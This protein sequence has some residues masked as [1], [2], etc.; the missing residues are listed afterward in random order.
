MKFVSRFYKSVLFLSL[1]LAP[2]AAL[3]VQPVID[4]TKTGIDV[5]LATVYPTWT[6]LTTRTVTIPGGSLFNCEVTCTSTVNNPYDLNGEQDNYYA[7][8]YTQTP[9]LDGCVRRFD[10]PTF[11]PFND[12]DESD[13]LVVATTCYL[14][15][16]AGT[17]EFHCLGTKVSSSNFSTVVDSTSMHVICIENEG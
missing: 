4:G 15:E 6:V 16:L 5:P 14:P 13:K 7:A 10:F 12:F 9:P 11:D 2:S 3:A 1:T 17:H 8:Y